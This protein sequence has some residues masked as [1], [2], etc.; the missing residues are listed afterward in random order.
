MTSTPRQTNFMEFLLICIEHGKLTP[1]LWNLN[2][3]SRIWM[4]DHASGLFTLESIPLGQDVVM[5]STG[6]GIAPFISMLRTYRNEPPWCHVVVIHGVRY[7]ADLSYR[8]ELE[9]MA[10]THAN[11]QYIPM[12]SREGG[13]AGE[14]EDVDVGRGQFLRGRV[15]RL[16]ESGIY[17]SLTGRTLDP[18][19]CHVMLCGNPAMIESVQADLEHRGFCTQTPIQPGNIHFERYW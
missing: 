4:D 18:H 8:D 9:A 7:I 16:L 10:R 11:M 1:Q 17:K 6:T 13:D 12:V 3:G 19:R 2:V 5:V 14:D 15:Q